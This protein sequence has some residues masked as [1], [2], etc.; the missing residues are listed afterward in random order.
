MS[1]TETVLLK[2]LKGPLVATMRGLE[3]NR[4]A[5]GTVPLHRTA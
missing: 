1:S 4:A 2:A 5:W 3:S